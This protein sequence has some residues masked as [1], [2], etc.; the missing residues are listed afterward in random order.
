MIMIT[1]VSINNKE[2]GWYTFFPEIFTF[3]LEAI[4]RGIIVLPYPM[5]TFVNVGAK[6]RL[7]S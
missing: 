7:W 5:I 3:M 2:I 1:M 4:P 6:S